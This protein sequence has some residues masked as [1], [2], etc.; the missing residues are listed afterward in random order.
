MQ[1]LAT[2]EMGGTDIATNEV[3]AKFCSTFVCRDY[4]AAIQFSMVRV[5]L[6]RIE[7]RLHTMLDHGMAFTFAEQKNTPRRGVFV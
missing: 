5:G 3:E 6:H 4:L 1:A 7:R 2:M